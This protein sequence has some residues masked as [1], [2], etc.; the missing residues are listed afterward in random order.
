[1]AW[2]IHGRLNLDAAAR[3]RGRHPSW[4]VAVGPVWWRGG[5]QRRDV[6]GLALRVGYR[7]WYFS[8]VP[9]RRSP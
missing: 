6:R 7:M 2:E 8:L 3:A 9:G 4:P 1:M 5:R